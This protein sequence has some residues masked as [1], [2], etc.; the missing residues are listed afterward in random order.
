MSDKNRLSLA[1]LIQL[2][3]EEFVWSLSLC[4]FQCGSWF[5][6]LSVGIHTHTH[7]HTCW[8]STCHCDITDPVFFGVRVLGVVGL[9]V[10]L[11]VGVGRG[12]GI[13]GGGGGAELGVGCLL[14]E[15]MCTQSVYA[16]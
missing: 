7:T 8:L 2:K 3:A 15:Q 10:C 1:R 4:G 13:G 5:G 14:A 16:V 11:G 9:C 12:G 6:T